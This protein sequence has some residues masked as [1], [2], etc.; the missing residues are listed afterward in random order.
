MGLIAGGWAGSDWDRAVITLF[1]ENCK[2][3]MGFAEKVVGK[4]NENS[5][6]T[7]KYFSHKILKEY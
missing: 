5:Q 4:N 1:A 3:G 7:G 2:R 6:R